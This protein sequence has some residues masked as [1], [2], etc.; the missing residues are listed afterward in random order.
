MG[1]NAVVGP[2]GGGRGGGGQGMPL[3]GGVPS[4]GRGMGALEGG[5]REITP[6]ADRPAQ[7]PQRSPVLGP[8]NGPRAFGPAAGEGNG[9]GMP[10]P[11]PQDGRPLGRMDGPPPRL[12]ARQEFDNRPGV[13]MPRRPDAHGTSEMGRGPNLQPAPDLREQLSGRQRTLPDNPNANGSKG[14]SVFDR[15]GA[16]P[17]SAGGEQVQH[18]SARHGPD[19][20]RQKQHPGEGGGMR[21]AG[22]VQQRP[23][24]QQ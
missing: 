11:G 1:A 24:M 5:R 22:G 6:M 14:R 17:S 16:P 23:G 19:A 2:G 9:A 13:N 10:R 12:E 21:H 4:G 20:Q 7:G 18:T 3:G 15:L 8:V